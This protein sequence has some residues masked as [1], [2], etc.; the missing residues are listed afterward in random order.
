L[1]RPRRARAPAARDD[2]PGARIQERE[3]VARAPSSGREG[4]GV[5]GGLARVLRV[6]RGAERQEAHGAP[7][8]T[9]RFA[10]RHRQALWDERR[11]H[12][13]GEPP[14]AQRRADAWRARGGLHRARA[15]ARGR[16]PLPRA[17]G[18]GDTRA[19]GTELL[20][21]VGHGRERRGGR[22]A[23]AR[24]RLTAK[25]VSGTRGTAT[26]N[27]FGRPSSSRLPTT[28]QPVIASA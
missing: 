13:A 14:L 18:A 5:G 16:F 2:A 6:L 11:V 24:R 20:G 12:G 21:G 9:R 27:A 28:E 23:N 22:A 4:A 3:A 26:T 7:G 1:E 10:R 8:T 15:A 17:H 25:R 19:R